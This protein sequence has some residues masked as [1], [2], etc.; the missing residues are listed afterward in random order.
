MCAASTSDPLRRLDEL[1]KNLKRELLQWA[2]SRIGNIREQLLMA[3]SIILRLDQTAE[4]RAL[5]DNEHQLRKDLKLKVL[6]ES[7]SLVLDN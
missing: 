1:L 6:G 5:S 4:C 2:A 3:R 7:P